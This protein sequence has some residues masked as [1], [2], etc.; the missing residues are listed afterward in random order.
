MSHVNLIYNFSLYLL[1]CALCFYFYLNC[2]IINIIETDSQDYTWFLIN[3]P[4][5]KVMNSGPFV[6]SVLII[7]II[8]D[9][10]SHL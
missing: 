1:F 7:I 6:T 4:M 10:F 3:G 9:T 5:F 8:L 2:F